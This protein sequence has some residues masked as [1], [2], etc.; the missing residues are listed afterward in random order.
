MN[1]EEV[2]KQLKDLIEDRKAFCA[3]D[4][5]PI[6]D[7]DIEALK[8]AIRELEKTALE[9]PVREQ[10]ITLKIDSKEIANVVISEF[11]KQQ[12]QSNVTLVV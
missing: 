1:R 7:K 11:R 12:K 6:F 9:V 10:Y 4:Y 3:G 2:I 8:Y 5:D